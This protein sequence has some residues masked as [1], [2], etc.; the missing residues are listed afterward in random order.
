MNYYRVDVEKGYTVD[1][2]TYCSQQVFYLASTTEIDFA[3][4][5]RFVND[6]SA[7][8]HEDHMDILVEKMADNEKF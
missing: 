8:Q 4:I 1:D 3:Y 6:K 2:E 5:K 7:G